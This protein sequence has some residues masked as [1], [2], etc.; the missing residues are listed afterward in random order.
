MK[1]KHYAKA[2]N[3]N[4]AIEEPRFPV[5]QCNALF[6]AIL[7][8]DDIDLAAEL[9]DTILL[10]YSQ[11]QLTQCYRICLQL[12]QEGVERKLLGRI[13]EK[14]YWHRSLDPEMQLAFKNMRAKFKHL[15]FAYTTFDANHCYPHE[16]HRIIVK[17]GNL[18][19]AFKHD[20]SSD[21]RR[22]A[23]FLRLLSIN[24]VYA[25][26]TR[27]IRRFRPTTNSAFRDYVN[28][29][30]HY[31]RL[32]LVEENVNGRVFHE[33]RKVISRQVALYDN[34]KVLYPS[35]YHQSISRYLSTINGLMGSMH[36]ELI[37]KHFDETQDY[38]SHTFTVPAKIRQLLTALTEKYEHPL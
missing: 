18:Q 2:D 33:M 28:S 37:A 14:F 24:I 19:D 4:E 26:S 8:H 27:K 3:H 16:F 10:E 20:K 23:I 38:E 6:A 35:P 7:V 12:W 29:E 34:L 13:A 22:S 1:S 25:F 17:M 11:R 32:N 36:D 30:I 5:E 31:I 9:P 15:R 21:I